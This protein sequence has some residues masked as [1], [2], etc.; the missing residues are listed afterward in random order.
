MCFAW[1]VVV[2]SDNRFEGSA[3]TAAFLLPPPIAN[4]VSGEGSFG[5]HFSVGRGGTGFSVKGQVLR[6]QN[7]NSL[8]SHFSKPH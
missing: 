6:E 5:G 1:A 8:Q 4:L 7:G 2:R 3:R